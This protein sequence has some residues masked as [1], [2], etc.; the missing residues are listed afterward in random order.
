MCSYESDQPRLNSTNQN[1]SSDLDLRPQQML[2]GTMPIWIQKCPNCGYINKSIQM[3]TVVTSEFIKSEIYLNF[4]GLNPKSD[5]AGDFIR[6]ALISIQD[7]DFLSAFDHYLHAAWASDDIKD[8]TCAKS[9][10]LKAVALANS[11]IPSIDDK[12]HEEIQ[13]IV[14]DML[15]RIGFFDYVI[16]K[17]ES[18]RFTI[19]EHQQIKLFQIS[20]SREHD[21]K[22]YTISNA[23]HGE[24]IDL[25]SKKGIKEVSRLMLNERNDVRKFTIRHGVKSI[26]FASFRNCNN[27]ENVQI[28][29]SVNKIDE[30]GFSG[31]N[32]LNSVT[33]PR[34]LKK[35][36]KKLFYGCINLEGVIIPE[37]VKE[38]GN[39]AFQ[40]CSS[41]TE[42]RLP[43]SVKT[44]GVG[45]FMDCTNLSKIILPSKLRQIR[46]STF[47]DCFQL[48]N[49]IIP[50]HVREIDESAFSGTLLEHNADILSKTTTIEEKFDLSDYF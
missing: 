33:L 43:N 15:R 6:C 44:I 41:L 14:A 20:K 16:E 29:D 1:G 17:L 4:N 37:G 40:K 42:V 26:G 50:E 10:R 13:L 45:A 47:S 36:S 2:R 30:E 23:V 31:C 19:P 9:C 34:H 11:H 22:V 49:L 27:L 39:Y 25:I 7:S 5:L 12:D 32:S 8:Y 38:I 18:I 35:I 48:Q 21:S 46:S 3:E 28:P 24:L